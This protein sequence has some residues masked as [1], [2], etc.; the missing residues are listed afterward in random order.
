[1]SYFALPFIGKNLQI[2]LVAL[3][4]APSFILFGYNQA[5]LGSLLSLQSW[6][7]L[8]PEID[9]VN[10]KGALKSHNST[11]QGACNASFQIGCLLGALSLSFYGDKLGRRKVIVMAAVITILGQVLQ[12]SAYGLPQFVVGRVILGFAIGQT[13]GTVPVWQSESAS[14]K[15]RGQHVICTGIFISTGYALC[16]WI[17]FGFSYLPSSTYQWRAPLTFSFLFSLVLIIFTFAFPESPRWLVGKGRIQE[18]TESLARYRGKSFE[19]P[20]VKREIEGIILSF[21]GTKGSSL[22]DM[23]RKDDQTRL[24]FRFCLCMGLNFFQQASQ[25]FSADYIATADQTRPVAVT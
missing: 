20:E 14:S 7:E 25:V 6:V 24:L 10:T 9:T 15:H 16:N 18:A 8:F 19:D 17:D 5:V 11:S 12:T 1:M 23:F 3:V 22:K 4:V 21:E 13:S 2:A